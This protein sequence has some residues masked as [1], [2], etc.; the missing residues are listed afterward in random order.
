MCLYPKEIKNRKYTPNKKNG[1]IIPTATD[2]RTKYVQVGC[3]RCI[4][5]TKQRARG[6]QVRLYEEI[7]HDKRG[8]FVTLT[9]NNESIKKIT[10]EIKNLTGYE[11]DNEIATKAVRKFLERYRKKYKKSIKHWLITELGHN[12]TENIHIHGIIWTD[13]PLAEIEKIWSYG[14][15]WKG[16]GDKQENYVNDRTINYIIK[17]VT[18]IDEIHKYYKPKILTSKGIGKAW[19]EKRNQLTNQ[20]KP[21]KTKETYKTKTGHEIALPLYYRNKIYTEEEKEKLWIEK[22]N[23]GIRYI[24]KEKIEI[25]TTEQ[26]KQFNDLQKWYQKINKKLGYGDDQ[27][28]QERREYEQNKRN[29]MIKKRTKEK[30]PAG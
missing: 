5:C 20:Y 6:W 26:Q 2:E 13:L 12:G 16:K 4:E 24:M 23:K 18:K 1:G 15:M 14:W 8:K 7:K 9:F 27:V 10:E 11:L 17:Y 28:N 22:M 30:P 19:I 21:H 29:E 3:G 25:K